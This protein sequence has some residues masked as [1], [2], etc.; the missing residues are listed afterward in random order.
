LRHQNANRRWIPF[1]AGCFE[2]KRIG[3]ANCAN[4]WHSPPSQHHLGQKTMEKRKKQKKRMYRLWA[5]KQ[6]LSG[7]QVLS[8]GKMMDVL[9]VFL[10]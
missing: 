7:K 5:R 1:D 2:P 3:K 4:E 8:V 6:V 10:A 9:L